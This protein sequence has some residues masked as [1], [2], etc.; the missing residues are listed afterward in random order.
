M[1]GV[2]RHI[3]EALNIGGG[4]AAGHEHV[5]EGVDGGLNQHVGDGEQGGLDAGGQ[6]DAEHLGELG[7]VESHLTQIQ[8][9]GIGALHQRPGD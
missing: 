9:A 3:D 7:L 6:A 2:Q 5:A 4:R 1:E 8:M